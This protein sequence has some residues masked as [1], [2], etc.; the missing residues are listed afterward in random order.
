[1]V[2]NGCI[3]ERLRIILPKETTYEKDALLSALIPTAL[4]AFSTDPQLKKLT[5]LGLMEYRETAIVLT[6]L[7]V[8]LLGILF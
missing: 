7:L 4:Q 5:A 3:A 8:S 6:Q 1:V 2:G